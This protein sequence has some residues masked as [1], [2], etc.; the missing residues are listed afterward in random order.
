MF[1]NLT[2]NIIPQIAIALPI[3]IFGGSAI[4]YASNFL[5]LLG[6]G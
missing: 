2:F 6:L 3:S 5:K 1:L 4:G